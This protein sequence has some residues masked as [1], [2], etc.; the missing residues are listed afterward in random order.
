[1]PKLLTTMFAVLGFGIAASGF[2]FAAGMTPKAAP[3]PVYSWT[4]FYVGGN[5]GYS[6]GDPNSDTSLT[7]IGASTTFGPFAFAHSDPLKLQ[8]VIGGAQI[9]YNWQASPDWV[10][11]LEADWQASGEAA[12]LG[13]SDPYAGRRL[14]FQAVGTANTNDNAQ[15][16]WFGT[17]RGR[18]GYAL[19]H[20]LIYG[21]GGL[22]YGQVQLEGTT[23]DSG[24]TLFI[25][26]P[27]CSPTPFGGTAPFGAS[28]VSV[29]WTAGAGVEGAL[30]GNW[31]WKAEYLYVDLGSLDLFAPGPFASETINVHAR[32]TDNILRVGFNYKFGN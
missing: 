30:A 22:A 8:G 29:G 10:Y 23:T 25:C 20:V 19:D 26:G 12:A 14:G 17:L 13:Y 6:W 27:T 11:G 7:G 31:T 3:A 32:F 18:V 1:M 28:R 9:G 24:S 21:T 16:P 15:I 2:A 5:L 4:G